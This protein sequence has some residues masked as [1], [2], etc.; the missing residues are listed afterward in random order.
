MTVRALISGLV[1]VFAMLLVPAGLAAVRPD[2]QAGPLGVGGVAQAET[3]Q[4]Q[5]YG[6][7][8]TIVA[9]LERGLDAYGNEISAVRPDDRADRF[10]PVTAEPVAVRPDDRAGRF[11]P[12]SE[13]QPVAVATEDT[14]IAWSDP[15]VV[16]LLTAL[17]AGLATVAVVAVV[18]RHGGGPGTRGMPG[19]P[20]HSH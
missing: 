7:A 8:D 9:R 20:T 16:G 5:A 12:G 18:H 2:D 1:V 17:V 15:L 4:F 19:T 10:T 3:L 13:A 6:T 11:T 14:G